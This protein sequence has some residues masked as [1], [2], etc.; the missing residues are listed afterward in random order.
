MLNADQF[1]CV[2]DL[3]GSTFKRLA[4]Q[5]ATQSVDSQSFKAQGA[6]IPA[7]CVLTGGTAPAA[8]SGLGDAALE[9]STQQHIVALKGNRCFQVYLTPSSPAALVSAA[10][11]IAGRL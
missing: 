11:M 10:Q 1:E 8:V 9:D 7:V 4:V 2:Y 6:D 5:L 3:N